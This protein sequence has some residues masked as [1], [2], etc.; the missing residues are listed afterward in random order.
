MHW[1]IPR[2]TFSPELD[3]REGAPSAVCRGLHLSL[4]ESRGWRTSEVPSQGLS[5]PSFPGWHRTQSRRALWQVLWRRMKP[6]VM[7]AHHHQR[8]WSWHRTQPQ[9]ADAH[10]GRCLGRGHT[11]DRGSREPRTFTGLCWERSRR[12]GCFPVCSPGTLNPRQATK[13]TWYP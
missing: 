9:E 3:G 4:R 7:P 2:I 1:R 11:G 8:A 5:L 12:H 10:L 13:V 6:W